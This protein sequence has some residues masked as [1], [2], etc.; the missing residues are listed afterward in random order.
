MIVLILKNLNLD[1]SKDKMKTVVLTKP[2]LQVHLDNILQISYN[3][4]IR[5]KRLR[6]SLV[7]EILFHI[8]SNSGRKKTKHRL[9]PPNIMNLQYYREPSSISSLKKK[10]L[11]LNQS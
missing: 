11:K 1:L 3:F 10:I 7:K 9:K 4:I 5:R 8:F 2:K 6:R